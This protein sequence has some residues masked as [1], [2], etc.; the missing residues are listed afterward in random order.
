MEVVSQIIIRWAIKQT[1]IDD[2]YTNIDDMYT[3]IDDKH[4][5]TDEW[6]CLH[7]VINKIQMTWFA[8]KDIIERTEWHELADDNKIRWLIAASEYGQNVWMIEYS[9]KLI[10]Q[11]LLH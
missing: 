3:N 2:M 11:N 5:I 4:T 1:N 7:H 9:I 8:V 6:W 10:K